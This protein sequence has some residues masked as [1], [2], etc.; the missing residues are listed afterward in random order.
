MADPKPKSKTL[1]SIEIR[2]SW[3][4]GCGLCIDYCNLGVL[5]MKG[6]KPEV[7]AIDKCTR[8][9]QCEVICPDF[10]IKVTDAAAAG[11]PA[12]ASAPARER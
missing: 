4:K 5:K 3:C 7:V 2:I 6:V 10:A 12:P 9:M 1:P 11:E 8:C